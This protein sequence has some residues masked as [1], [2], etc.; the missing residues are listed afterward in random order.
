MVSIQLKGNNMNKKEAERNSYKK[1]MLISILTIL[2]IIV[3]LGIVIVPEG[4][5]AA[6]G[7]GQNGNT[8]PGSP[9]PDSAGIIEAFFDP[10]N[11]ADIYADDINSLLS[12]EYAIYYSYYMFGN[13]SGST[14]TG[15]SIASI[16]DTATGQNQ[17]F[18]VAG[19]AALKIIGGLICLISALSSMMKE[20]EKGDMT[21]E[22]WLR[23]ML[24][25]VIPCILIM[26]Y[27]FI[28][29][30]LATIGLWIFNGVFGATIQNWQY[31]T[32]NGNPAVTTV[33]GVSLSS[34]LTVSI[35][36]LFRG[37]VFATFLEQL[38]TYIIALIRGII[39]EMALMALNLGIVIMIISAA[40]GSIIEIYI[41]HLFMPLAIANVSHEGVRSAGF[42]YIKKYFGCFLS[43]ATLALSIMITF[44]IY[45]LLCVGTPSTPGIFT[46]GGNV[47][48]VLSIIL[49]FV[50]VRKATKMNTQIVQEALGD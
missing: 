24:S 48:Q 9:A 4:V 37:N 16:I 23:I 21:M 45:S 11:V 40:F 26:E 25:F 47:G 2:G 5:H 13:T 27:D 44:Y 3:C 30:A 36:Q 14:G 15:I 28:I 22:S 31:N 12:G 7:W 38:L 19:T 33:T 17:T 10:N 18:F 50:A 6:G 29:K 20:L 43:L 39:Y 34:I 32:N 49:L 35:S 1:R 41:R 46:L 42:R 8:N